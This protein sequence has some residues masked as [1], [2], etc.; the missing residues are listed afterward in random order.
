MDSWLNKDSIKQNISSIRQV[1]IIV[2]LSITNLE[3]AKALFEQLNEF[4]TNNPTELNLLIRDVTISENRIQLYF[5]NRML[6]NLKQEL[7]RLKR[8]LHN[9]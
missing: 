9:Y 1:I 4:T 8:I 7:N 6:H 3:E 2:Q 5:K